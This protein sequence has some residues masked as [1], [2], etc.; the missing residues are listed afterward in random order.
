MD[1]A[2]FSNDNDSKGGFLTLST[3][4]PLRE[5]SQRQEFLRFKISILGR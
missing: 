1:I 3:Q 2:G 5:D 4:R